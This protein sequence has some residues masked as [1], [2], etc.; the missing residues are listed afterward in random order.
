MNVFY[1]FTAS[2]AQ[3]L[4]F[5]LLTEKD[6][7]WVHKI[8]CLSIENNSGDKDIDGIKCSQIF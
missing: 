5:T 2:T 7:I 4:F 6:D 3:D 8:G 1:R